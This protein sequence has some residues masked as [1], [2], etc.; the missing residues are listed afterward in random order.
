LAKI[1]RTDFVQ[2][3]KVDRASARLVVS[4]DPLLNLVSRELKVENS[5]A[6]LK[7]PERMYGDNLKSPIIFKPGVQL[8]STGGNRK[9]FLSIFQNR[10]N[11]KTNSLQAVDFFKPYCL[12]FANAVNA[13]PSVLR[14][15]ESVPVETLRL[16]R[17]QEN[18]AASS[19][20]LSLIFQLTSSRWNR[21]ECHVASDGKTTFAR[22][23]YSDLA[24]VVG[25]L[26]DLPR[27]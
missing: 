3:T 15:A 23:G 10:N 26:I 14:E 12:L 2:T 27:S 20:K 22:F 24:D 18:I 21:F 7:N 17:R 11:L 8:Y 25:D 19:D 16:Q 4:L 6:E 5:N 13:P 9:Q 1:K